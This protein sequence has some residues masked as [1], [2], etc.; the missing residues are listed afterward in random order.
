MKS[1]KIILPRE[2]L[3]A[4]D[5]RIDGKPFVGVINEGLLDFSHKDVFGWYLSL[6][7]D[8]EKTVGE[9]MPDQDD[10]RVM[11]TFSDALTRDLSGNPDHPNVLFL[12]RFTGDGH[13]QLIWYVNNPE[14]ADKYLKGLIESNNYPFDFEYEMTSDPEWSEA[15]YWLNSFRSR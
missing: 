13:T 2:R 12:G 10:T 7:I 3:A 14:T 4:V 8:Y 5:M 6:I 15:D 11:Q 1:V 9:G